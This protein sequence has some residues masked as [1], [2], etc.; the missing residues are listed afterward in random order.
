VRVVDLDAPFLDLELGSPRAGGSYRSL[1][2]VLRVDGRPRGATILSLD[3]TGRVTRYRLRHEIRQLPL[4][5][6]P[7]SARA[8]DT[9]RRRSMSVVVTTCRDPVTLERCLRSILAC[10]YDEFEV[11]VVENRPGSGETQRMLDER[12]AGKGRVRYLEEAVPGLAVARNAGL[13]LAEGE[14][15]A[16]TDDDVLVDPGWLRA[17]A[18]AFD[19][20]GSVS[21]VT[22]LILPRELETRAQHLFEEFT[23][24]GKG[25]SARVYRLPEAREEDPLMPFAPGTIG[26]GANTIL[27]ADVARQ[28]GGFAPELGAGTLAAGGEDLDLYV[29][30]LRGGHAIAYEP[31]AL[32]WHTH[33][34]GMAHLRRQAYR[35]GVGLGAALGR[36]LI[37][38]PGREE[39]LRAVP[40][41]VRHLRDP[42]S[43]KNARKPAGYPRH[44]DLLERLGMLVGPAAYLV[45]ALRVRSRSTVRTVRTAP[46]APEATRAL[47]D[48]GLLALI[49][50][51]ATAIVASIDPI[52]PFAV[53]AAACLVPGSAL[54][55]RLRGVDDVATAAGLAIALS[56]SLVT[57]GSLALAWTGWW[58]PELLALLLGGGSAALL[59]A[60]LRRALGGARGQ[61][62]LRA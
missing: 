45:S 40:A 56:L 6:V 48:A 38:C 58:H 26:S 23:G 16:F 31:S 51:T 53:F 54:M 10:D 15:V 32:V 5:G 1:L 62:E 14:L 46:S 22:G 60:D 30:L 27:R 17:C 35:Y 61:S 52:R 36:Q 34:D 25:F 12:F 3:A 4:E 19:R 43:R 29:R 28:I 59:L 13:S 41:G 42:A 24:F 57:A 44:L 50:L 37:A 39:L 8:A 11:V 21:C 33:P 55:T 2:A 9:R 20:P 47:I 18:E 49:A 7:R